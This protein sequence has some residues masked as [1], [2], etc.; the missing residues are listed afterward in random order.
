[1]QMF[2]WLDRDE[3]GFL[4]HQD[5]INVCQD[6]SNGNISGPQFN[7]RNFTGDG[8]IRSPRTDAPFVNND[9]NRYAQKR[10]EISALSPIHQP[11]LNA[12]SSQGNVDD[13]VNQTQYAKITDAE[14]Q[15]SA[16]ELGSMRPKT[17]GGASKIINQA[18]D[19]FATING[20]TLTSC[21]QNDYQKD[22]LTDLKYADVK[23]QQIK[24]AVFQ[25]SHY[26]RDN[27]AQVLRQNDTKRKLTIMDQARK[28][29]GS[30]RTNSLFDKL[31]D[32]RS[33]NSGGARLLSE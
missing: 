3:D 16:D 26:R 19:R 7:S 29:P 1:M 15:Y 32:A 31:T 8:S 6:Y 12:V 14:H 13:Y 2:T 22:Y 27:V 17:Y 11:R 5:F 28:P 9:L 23:K 18:F 33:G 21:I 30:V 20:G 24:N 4:R 25:M 10:K